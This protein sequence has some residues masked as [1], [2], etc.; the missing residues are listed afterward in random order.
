MLS[1]SGARARDRNRPC[2]TVLDY[3]YAYEHEHDRRLRACNPI[4]RDSVVPSS[5]LSARVRV[6]VPRH[7]V[8]ARV[9]DSDR[10]VDRMPTVRPGSPVEAAGAHYA[11]IMFFLHYLVLSWG[12]GDA[13]PVKEF[14]F[15]G[16]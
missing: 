3:D 4:L 11:R 9:P 7:C 2:R 13:K 12:M 16:N 5:W 6:R 10:R 15:P 14:G 1:E 8:R